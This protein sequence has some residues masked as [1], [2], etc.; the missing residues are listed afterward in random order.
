MDP[1]C[2]ATTPLMGTSLLV[3]AK[4]AKPCYG[5]EIPGTGL[6]HSMG[7]GCVSCAYK[8]VLLAMLVLHIR[9]WKCI[10]SRILNTFHYPES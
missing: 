1:C 8:N 3:L 4:M 2:A 7:M 6:A 10:S 5:G 9:F